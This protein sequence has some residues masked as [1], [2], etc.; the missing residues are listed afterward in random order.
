MLGASPVMLGVQGTTGHR[1]IAGGALHPLL[2]L[3]RGQSSARTVA[4]GSDDT[5][6]SEFLA[7]TPRFHGAARRLLIE[8]QRG[9]R[10][11]NPRADGTVAGTP[12]A[13]PTNWSISGLPSGVTA[14][15][16]GVIVVS[17]VPCL[18]LQISGTPTTTAS[19]RIEAE[20]M[21][22][23]A[24]SNG[25][26]W[27][28]S[29]FVRLHAGT[30]ANL[31]LALRVMGRDSA[32]A[33]YNLASS[34]ITL[35]ASLERRI[36]STSLA[37]S[38]VT[39]AS[40]DIQI[41]FTANQPVDCTIDIGWPQMEQASFA[42]SPVLPL[43]GA[44]ATSTRGADMLSAPL[45]SLGIGGNGACTVLI[46]AVLPQ[47]APGSLDQ[48]LAE[49][50][51]G[52]N[53]NRFRMFNVAGGGTVNIGRSLGGS[54]QTVPAGTM[55]PGT[56]LRIGMA[57]DGSGRVAGSLNGGAVVVQTGG[58]TSGL[59]TLRIGNNATNSGPLCGLI[60]EC[61]V[62]PYAVPDNALPSVVAALPG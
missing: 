7:D 44:V 1:L 20:G 55:V 46:S 28:A 12:G 15:I 49:L 3:T 53:N 43:P 25:Q 41:G 22:A 38:S 10:I 34:A 4:L 5:T 32:Y 56:L 24:A 54:G 45:A 21:G 52:T 30:Q 2:V 11:R 42:S 9:N 16:L 62:L 23:I 8:G 18:R 48:M 17:G 51:D 33:A 58:P 47:N 26:G 19:G 50:D 61:R 27:T 36:V 40:S 37:S 13:M 57:I 35:G 39:A 31:S 60:G 14:S 59:T 6:W 29:K